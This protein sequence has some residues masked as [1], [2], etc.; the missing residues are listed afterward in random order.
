MDFRFLGIIFLSSLPLAP[1]CAILPKD[2]VS[3]TASEKQDILWSQ[4]EA[5]PY[6]PAP[7][8][9]QQPG[10]KESLSLFN[11]TFMG[12]SFSHVSDEVPPGRRR[13]VH[14]LGSLVK[15]ELITF[16]SS[17][18]G[19]FK[20]G[21]IGLFRASLAS[22]P[23]KAFVPGFAYKILVDGR[24]SV[25]L[26]ALNSTTGQRNNTNFF[27]LSKSNIIVQASSGDPGIINAA[28]A[29]AAAVRRLPGG[30]DDKPVS[31]VNLPMYEAASIESSGKRV[32]KVVAPFKVN[33]IPNPSAGWDPASTEDFRVHLANI[34]E[35]T[36]L[37]TVEGMRTLNGTA[38]KIGK[39]VTRSPFFGSH[40][41]DET[42]FFEHPSKR[43]KE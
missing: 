23:R 26:F 5:S 40:Y 21:G 31:S 12:Q 29:F 16:P 41:G 42:L 14:A 37:Y 27:A 35:G 1:V 22:D 6:T 18:T 9:T 15:I 17:F 10:P 13:L 34:A 32:E 24:A 28:K 8:P 25:N 36:V 33:Y 20:S 7:L 4:I 11:L 30:P 3:K 39:L 19:V 38:E 43:W 2:Y